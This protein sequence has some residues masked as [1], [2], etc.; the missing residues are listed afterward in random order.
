MTTIAVLFM[1]MLERA[2]MPTVLQSIEYRAR[3]DVLAECGEV[4]QGCLV[5]TLP[6]FTCGPVPAGGCVNVPCTYIQTCEPR[7]PRKPKP[8]PEP[9][10]AEVRP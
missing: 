3:E 8:R 4:V 7:A 1:L 5:F 6:E 9:M 2:P 10:V